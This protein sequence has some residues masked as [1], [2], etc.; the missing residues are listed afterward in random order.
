MAIIQDGG[1]IL[2]V[3]GKNTSGKFRPLIYAH[4]Y[5]FIYLFIIKYLYRIH[6]QNIL[7]YN[8]VRH[9]KLMPSTHML[10]PIGCQCAAS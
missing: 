3:Y 7:V 5:L 2:H 4:I 1:Q 6:I 8:V 10:D 9:R